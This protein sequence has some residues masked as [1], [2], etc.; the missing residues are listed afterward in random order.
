MTAWLLQS[1]RKTTVEGYRGRLVTLGRHAVKQGLLA[2]TP[3]CPVVASHHRKT[4]PPWSV[5]ELNKLFGSARTMPGHVAGIA[6]RRW[7]PALLLTI[8]DTRC[9]PDD[10]LQIPADAYDHRAGSL[11]AGCFL[12]KPHP[13]TAEALDAI[14]GHGQQRLLPWHLD[15][16]R[17]PFHMLYRQF[18]TVLWR[19]RLPHVTVNL[20]QRLRITAKADAGILDQLDLYIPFTPQAGK[21]YL[22]RAL[23]RRQSQESAAPSSPRQAKRKRAAAD[24]PPMY[25]V[26]NNSPRSLRRF[27]EEIYIPRRMT[28]CADTS[29]AKH[30]TAVNKLC[31]WAGCE[32]TLD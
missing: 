25:L 26:G 4:V 1:Q 15:N 7:W 23:H 24:D 18:K 2:E 12:F 14:R 29:K 13:Y 6:A 20:F 21:P 3:R 28:N 5:A 9:A 30:R 31:D 11:A 19:A 10:A 8:L 16:G 22:P 27:V 17:P 32:V